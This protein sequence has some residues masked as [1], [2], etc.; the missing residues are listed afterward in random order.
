MTENHIPV[1][2]REEA[3]AMGLMTPPLSCWACSAPAV[4]DRSGA[5]RSGKPLACAVIFQVLWQYCPHEQNR[6][7][8]QETCLWIV[9]NAVSGKEKQRALL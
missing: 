7:A 2:K 8:V 4:H 9:T 3:V 6:F 1:S 5:E